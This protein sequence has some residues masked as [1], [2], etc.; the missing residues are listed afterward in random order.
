MKSLKKSAEKIY[1][2]ALAA[3]NPQAAVKKYVKRRN[4]SLS[5]A[6]VRYRLKDYRNM[7]VLGAGKAA[8]SMAR[9]L[10][11]ILG[12]RITD[13][14]VIVK[15]GHG[16][17]LRR[18]KLIEAGHPE[19]DEN[20]LRGAQAIT[21]MIRQKITGSDLVFFLLSGGASA[22]MVQ[23]AE[24]I[25]LDDKIKLNAQL[26]RSG[27]TIQEMN[28]VRKHISQIKGGRISQALAN[29]HVITLI[30]SDV[31]GDDLSTIG[32]GPTVP[33]PTSFKD[34][35]DILKKYQL[36][37]AVPESIRQHLARGA[38]GKVAETPKVGDP[39]FEHKQNLIIA[40]NILA[41]QAAAAQ[42]RK[43]KFHTT[44]LSSSIEG[45]TA[46]VARVHLAIARETI[47]TGHPI[48]LPA[49]I[50]SGGETTVHVKGNGQGGRNQEF[51][52]HGVRA[53]AGFT[54]KTLLLSLGTDGTDGPTDAAGAWADNETFHEAERRALCIE[55]YLE[56]NDSYH[57]FQALGNLII[58]GPTKT[59][60]MD[61]RLI[62]IN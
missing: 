3:V 35:L 25:S 7:Y 2:A 5:V 9:A 36:T 60:V 4:D 62:L 32:S 20:G 38:E 6:T 42:A 15:Y 55:D 53:L 58:T 34:C 31:V 10:E 17:R 27:A 30:L 49:C 33:D 8:A 16:E 56:R 48:K 40:S 51:V 23:P 41:C 14:I 28:A 61:L 47:A 57:F 19:P 12:A 22:L 50:I 52:L 11:T 43:L 54:R 37:S 59:N 24:G 21:E 26:L 29:N 39:C 45:D 46:E 1:K 13:G 44:I 18:V